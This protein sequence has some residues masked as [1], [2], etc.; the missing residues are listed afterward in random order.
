MRGLQRGLRSRAFDRCVLSWNDR[1]L[2]VFAQAIP[3]GT[4][5]AIAGPQDMPVTKRQLRLRAVS[6]RYSQSMT[7]EVVPRSWRR[8]RSARAWSSAATRSGSSAMPW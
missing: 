4:R 3:A 2:D 5:R 8:A 6:S 7:V 1:L